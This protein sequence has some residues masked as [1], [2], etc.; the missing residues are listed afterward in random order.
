MIIWSGDSL[1]SLALDI[2]QFIINERPIIEFQ[3]SMM[4]RYETH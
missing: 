3:P 1:S 4:A 2:H